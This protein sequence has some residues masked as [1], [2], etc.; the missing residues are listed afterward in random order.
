MKVGDL[1]KLSSYGRNRRRTEWIDADD[2]GI[3]TK[4]KSWHKYGDEYTVRW[5]KS[6]WPPT[7]R[8]WVAERGQTRKDLKYARL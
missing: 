5:Q 3:I 1:V 2:V 8:R 4:I 7:Y 6:M